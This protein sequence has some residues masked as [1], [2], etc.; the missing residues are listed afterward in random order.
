ME[1]V[2]TIKQA[3]A[4]ESGLYEYEVRE[5]PEGTYRIPRPIR[6]LPI[7]APPGSIIEFKDEDN[8]IKK[9]VPTTNGYRKV[10]V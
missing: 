7:S 6:I 10:P 3:M 9:I 4:L 2:T 5:T 1:P 8:V